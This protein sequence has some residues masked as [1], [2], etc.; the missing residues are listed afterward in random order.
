MNHALI[1]VDLQNDFLVKGGFYDRKEKIRITIPEGM[2]GDDLSEPSKPQPYALRNQKLEPVIDNVS[3]AVARARQLGWPIAFVLAA[4]GHAFESKPG[5]LRKSRLP[6]SDYPCK[7]G[8]W[9]AQ[10]IEPILKLLYPGG[11]NTNSEIVVHKHTLD[12]FVDTELLCFLL[13]RATESVCVC[14]VETDACV[15]ATAI[16]ASARFES[17]LLED[18]TWTSTGNSANALRIFENAFG[19]VQLWSSAISESNVA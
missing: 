7:P 2:S 11:Q 5:F 6:R 4:Y 18:C 13:E 19:H 17:I 14:G 15:L 9:G 16:S 1:V 3:Q 8:T 10:P 12:G